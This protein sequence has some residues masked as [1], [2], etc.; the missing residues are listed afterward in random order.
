MKYKRIPAAIHNFGDSFL[1]FM[2]YLD[3]GYVIDDLE[4]VHREGKD[5]EIDWL[6]GTF[7]PQDGMTQR[8][9]TSV[10]LHRN[11]LAGQLASE[12][13]DVARLSQVRLVWPAGQRR[14]MVAIDDRGREHRIYI[15]EYR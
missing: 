2:N 6:T 7:E 14:S 4:A 12:G 3:N 5:I 9:A 11:R 15:R 10:E 1:S 13:V 8:V